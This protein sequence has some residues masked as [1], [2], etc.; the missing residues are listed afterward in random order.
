[1]L[2]SVQ[3]FISTIGG[4]LDGKGRVCIPSDFRRILAAQNTP[5]VYVCPSRAP[6][7]LEAFGTELLERYH[8][9]LAAQDPFF[10]TDFDEKAFLVLS[11]TQL[12]P[13]DENGRARLPDELIARAG[14]KDR[15]MFVGMG[16][17]FRIW[18][19]VRLEEMNA[20]L[21]RAN[22]PAGETR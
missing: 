15:V 14:F 12:L 7:A 8:Q 18:E 10:S 6:G 20:A 4:T 22:S 16:I 2:V 17:K 5:G 21:E 11:K 9:L 19:P 13:L 3:P 1:M